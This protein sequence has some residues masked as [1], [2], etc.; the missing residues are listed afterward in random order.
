[1]WL[2]FQIILKNIN[3]IIITFFSLFSCNQTNMQHNNPK[4]NH[5]IHATSPY[6]Q[7]H[8]YNPVDWHQWG[9]VALSKAKKEG[10]LLFISIGYSA[11]HWCHVMEKESFENDSVAEWL[12]KYF[13]SIKV[14]REERPDIDQ[15]YMDAVQ[16]MTGGGGWP[17]NCFALPDGRPIYGGTYFKTSQFLQIV[18]QLQEVY[19]REPDKMLEYAEKLTL[20]ISTMDMIQVK[21]VNEG[22]N[23]KVLHEMVEKWSKSFDTIDG[24]PNYAPKFPMPNNYQFLMDYAFIYRD[25]N[26][27]QYVKLTLDKMKNGG[28]Y[29]QIGGG[30]AR[31][32]TD[33][34][35][36]VPHF[37]KMLY[38]NAQLA[39]L[40]FNAAKNYNSGTYEALAED[41]LAFV[42]RE[43]TNKDACFYTALDAD[44][45]GEEGKYYVW[46]K[47]E[48]Q[49]V[50]NKD[51]KIAA[52]LFGIET[53]GYWEN[54]HYILLNEKENKKVVEK[55]NLNA[56]EIEQ[57]WQRAKNKMLR[58]RSE[59]IKPDLDDKTIVS[60]NA[61][62]ATAYLNGYLQTSKIEYLT[63]AKK[64][65]DFL[66]TKM[67]MP[68][69][70][71]H[72]HYK[73]GKSYLHGMA[74]DY[75]FTIEACL[76]L[77]EAIFD[78]KYLEA[79]EELMQYAMQHFFDQESGFF[80]FTSSKAE[81]LIVRKKELND[82]VIPASNSVL[83]HQLFRLSIHLE[84]DVWKK[85]SLEMYKA[86]EGY[87]VNY[88][89]SYSNWAA[90]G[91]HLLQAKTEL[92]ICGD[93]A[94]KARL[95]VEKLKLPF[96]TVFAGSSK[97]SNK[98]LLLNRFVKG[99][100]LY[101]LCINNTC[102]KPVENVNE[103]F[104]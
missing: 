74:E 45:E 35:W 39:S 93:N 66:L 57:I 24:G 90:L 33:A 50:L 101:Y 26:L 81:K 77:Y 27:Q 10:K 76:Q 29:D 67:R 54:N 41:I 37:E 82:N 83:A 80:Y 36:K 8:A 44:S 46:T 53:T 94:I 1:L 72:H 56:D 68:D 79:A 47:D 5:L 84:N 69:G 22:A 59:R 78:E 6:L 51:F 88:P 100:T 62:M 49:K 11:C 48:L 34:Y 32:S 23:Q 31:Y 20:G 25:E 95:E 58:I 102:K 43:L 91:L 104:N 28:M 89:S 99:K 70:G 42:D 85:I 103:I 75:A 73:N 71:L 87:F 4:P 97:A 86:M 16:L 21:A 12:N 15:I 65:I 9:D 2:I 40:Y 18:K 92:V 7:Q 13:V 98:A 61:M 19:T 64:N 3:L 55:L 52:H 17:L 63:K 30:F 96:G 14:D 38:D 60:W